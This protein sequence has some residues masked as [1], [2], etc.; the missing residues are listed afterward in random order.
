MIVT[1][2]SKSSVAVAVALALSGAAHAAT[3]EEI[4]VTAQKRE[5]DLQD[6]GVSITPF[7]DNQMEDLGWDNSLDVAG[8]VKDSDLSRYIL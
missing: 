2:P 4:I 3:L 8:I 6:V 5:Q 1:R 7:T